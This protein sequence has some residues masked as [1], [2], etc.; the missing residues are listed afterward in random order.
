[1]ADTGKVVQVLGNVVD[2]EFT[3]ET[4]PKI[5]DALRVRVNEGSKAAGNGA[6]AAGAELGGTA[7]KERELVLEVQDELGNNQVRCLATGLDRRSRARRR[8]AR[9]GR[10]DSGSRGRRHARTHLQR[11]GRGDRHRRSRGCRRPLADPP[12]RARAEVSGA[13][14][15]R[16]RDRHQSR[17]LDGAL[18]ARR[19]GRPLRRRGRRQDGADPRAHSQHRVRAQRLLGVHRRRRAHARRQRPLARD[20]RIR[21]ARSDDARL[22]A[23][24]RAAG[25]PFP[26]RTDRRDDGGIL[27]R[28]ARRRRAALHRQ[29]LPLHAGGLRSLGADGPHAVGGRLSADARHRHGRA[30]R[31][32]HVDAQGLDHVG[33]GGVR[34]GRRLHRSGGR[35]DLRAPRRDD[36]ALAPDLRVGHLSRGRSARLNVAHPRSGDRRRGALRGGARRA[37]SASALPRPAGH[38]RDPRRRGAL[39]RR[40]DH[41]RAGAPH[42][43]LLLAAVLRRGTVYGSS[44]LLR[45]ARGDRRVVQGDPRG[46]G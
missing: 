29:H 24:G 9:D 32:H 18:H 11:A 28:R 35:H 13:D 27:P 30:R 38:H 17:R 4:L 26:R 42:A 22:R 45:Q 19:K 15:A 41:G 3:P 16:L 7:M 25:R 39:R 1:M 8:S 20:E 33:A 37:G 6:A 21:R 44:G 40:Q 12:A 31:A 2:V 14:G 43:T 10:P 23:D 46:Q 5:N 36:G 34:A